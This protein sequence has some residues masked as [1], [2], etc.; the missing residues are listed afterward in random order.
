MHD[1]LKKIIGN[2]QREIAELPPISVTPHAGIKSFKSALLNTQ[3]AVIAEIK[4][5]SPSK[6]ELSTIT[7][8][9]KLANQYAHGGATAIS[10]LT[11]TYAFNGCIEDLRQVAT[12]LQ[13]TPVVVLQK[14]FILEPIQMD[15][16]INAGA[17]AILL[18]VSVLKDKTQRLLQAAKLRQLDVLVEVHDLAELDYAISIGADII[19]VNNRDLT[20]FE[21]NPDN[22]L[23]L[24]PR[25]PAHIVTVAE[26]GINSVSAA[27]RYIDAGYQALL[28]GEALVK[29]ENP[30]S[31]IQ[32]IR[33]SS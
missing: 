30:A 15:Y 11:D 13:N 3:P 4:R 26:S 21:I 2:K 18:I 27:K 24:K 19:G 29:A 17:N 10:V 9:V 28:I 5:K 25:I 31:L 33:M 6:G 16:A 23:Q 8:P 22:A 12:A 20:T 1:Y 32:Q 14:D 7:D